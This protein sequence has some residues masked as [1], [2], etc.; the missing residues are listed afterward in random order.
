[1]K[2]DTLIELMVKD[3]SSLRRR[4]LSSIAFMTLAAAVSLTAL[5]FLSQIGLR[6]DL[7]V[8]H[9]LS[10]VA[11]KLSVTF[12]MAA[13]GVASALA[14][15]QADPARH[16]RV[17]I[18]LAVPIVVSVFVVSD[19]VQHGLAGS[20]TRLIGANGWTCL[21]AIPSLSI[22]PLA[23][24]L[25]TL[26]RGAATRLGLAGAVAGIAASGFGASLYALACTDDSPLFLCLWYGLATLVVAC[27]GAVAARVFLRW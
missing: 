27:C 21:I 25:F 23:A 11:M 7:Q 16:S 15:A 20:A 19:L 8:G 17:K 2:T 24:L 14:V 12:A 22:L 18:L 9:A 6:P 1:M 10:A 5:V 4:S 26:N 13:A 3:R